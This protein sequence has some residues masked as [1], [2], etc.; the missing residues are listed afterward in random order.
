MP[1][2]QR[3]GPLPRRDHIDVLAELDLGLRPHVGPPWN[4]VQIAAR[5]WTHKQLLPSGDTRAYRNPRVTTSSHA[6]PG[7]ARLRRRWAACSSSAVWVSVRSW[8]TR[9]RAVPVLISR[10]LRRV[11][12]QIGRWCCCQC[13]TSLARALCRRSCLRELA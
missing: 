2:S 8:V 6:V 4:A 10:R 3:G 13:S 11:S 9:S 5:T 12:A 7:S 1:W